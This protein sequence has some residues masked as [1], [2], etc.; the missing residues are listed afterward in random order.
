VFS[1]T[2]TT[3]SVTTEIVRM[4][5]ELLPEVVESLGGRA[6]THQLC[7]DILLKMAELDSLELV[8]VCTLLICPHFA[9]CSSPRD[10]Q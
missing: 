4:I 6:Q 1:P 7:V 5:A 10:F 8:V 2:S 3:R 9:D